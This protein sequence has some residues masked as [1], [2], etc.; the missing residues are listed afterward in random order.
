[1][2]KIAFGITLLLLILVSVIGVYSVVDQAVTLDYQGQGYA[3]TEQDMFALAELLRDSEQEIAEVEEKLK[4][5]GDEIRYIRIGDTIYLNRLELN[6]AN[7]KLLQ[8]EK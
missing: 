5:M 6:F 3:G 1:M 2:W 7:G 8:I 4:G